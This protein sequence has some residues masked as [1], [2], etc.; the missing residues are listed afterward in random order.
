MVCVKVWGGGC[1]GEGV[2]RRRWMNSF[3]PIVRRERRCV[4]ASYVAWACVGLALLPAP[5]RVSL[6]CTYTRDLWRWVCV[7]IFIRRSKDF[8]V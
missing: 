2:D 7:Y 3:R 1:R 8:L 4:M 5:P 6:S